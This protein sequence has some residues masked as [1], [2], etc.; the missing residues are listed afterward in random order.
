MFEDDVA[1]TDYHVWRQQSI[2]QNRWRNR[3]QANTHLGSLATHSEQQEIRPWSI[4]WSWWQN[5]CLLLFFVPSNQDFPLTLLSLKTW[6]LQTVETENKIFERWELG[7]GSLSRG[8]GEV[9]F[10]FF[11]QYKS[12]Y[13]T[14]SI[15]SIQSI[16]NCAVW[17]ESWSLGDNGTARDKD[18]GGS[19]RVRRSFG[20]L[21]R[22]PI[23]TY[24]MP[25]RQ[26]GSR[27][28]IFGCIVMNIIGGIRYHHRQL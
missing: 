18:T 10:L 23:L 4:N 7:Q 15:N 24:H 28:N 20:I 16:Y 11:K 19:V 17:G 25:I 9:Q 27:V 3:Q 13:S 8:G 12:I 1:M 22:G 26:E 21:G 5:S 2:S 6:K 14:H